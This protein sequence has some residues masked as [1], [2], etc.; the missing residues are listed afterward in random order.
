MAIKNAVITLE[1][2]SVKAQAAKAEECAQDLMTIRQKLIA[3]TNEIS[4]GWQGD[5]ATAFLEKCETLAEKIQISAKE[6]ERTANIIEKAAELYRKAEEN[7]IHT[8][9]T[10]SGGGGG[11]GGGG[12]FR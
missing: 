10:Y 11:G 3:L 8:V 12:S 5:A 7:A 9:S 1:Y 4:Q 6:I 2:K